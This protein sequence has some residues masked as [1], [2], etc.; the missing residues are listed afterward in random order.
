MLLVTRRAFI[1]QTNQFVAGGG[2]SKTLFGAIELMDLAT[3]VVWISFNLFLYS[4][5]GR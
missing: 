1:F 4:S 5:S 3:E 2:G